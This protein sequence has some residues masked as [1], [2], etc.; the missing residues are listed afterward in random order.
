MLSR[1]DKLRIALAPLHLLI[2][3]ILLWRFA[4][5]GEARILPVALLGGAWLAYGVYRLALVRRA[6]RS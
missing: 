6:L 1:S 2:G 5:D 4:T 3:A